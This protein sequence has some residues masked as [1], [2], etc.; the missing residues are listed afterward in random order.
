MADTYKMLAGIVIFVVFITVTLSMAAQTFPDLAPPGANPINSI[1]SEQNPPGFTA[2]NCTSGDWGC[3]ITNFL[4]NLGSSLSVGMKF[5][6]GL[7]GMLI[8]LFT[9][10]IPALQSSPILQMLNF[11]IVV[12]ILVVLLLFSFRIVKSIIPTVGGDTD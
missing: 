9:F 3:G 12:P 1:P 2:S 10:Q 11:L 4:G 6:G 8:A 7:F 5:V